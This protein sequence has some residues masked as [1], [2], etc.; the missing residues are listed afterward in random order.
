MAQI[1]ILKGLF[2]EKII[3]IIDIFLDNPNRQFSLTQ[4]SSVSN[5]NIATTMRMLEKL[6][7]Q[8]IVELIL[9]EKTKLYRLKKNEKTMA[10]NKLLKSEEE[11]LLEFIDYIKKFPRVKKI[12][13]ESKTDKEVKLLI[14]GNFLPIGKIKS[15]IREIREK[16]HFRINFVDLNENQF[17]DME[18]LG[19]YEVN[20]KIIW[21][22]KE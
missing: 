11:P 22:R 16:H 13:L 7:K 9:I 21:K 8:N 20:R 14:V 2:D 19:F 10:L 18:R 6:V 5:I 15:I 1:D 12:I 17:N 4:V 3:Q